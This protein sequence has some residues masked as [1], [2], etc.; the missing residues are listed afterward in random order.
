VDFLFGLA[1][2]SRW[3]IRSKAELAEAAEHSQQSGKSARRF[4]DFRPGRHATAGAASVASSPRRNGRRQANPRFVVTSLSREEHEARHLYEKALLRTRRDWRTGSRS[5]SSTL[6]RST[7]PKQWR[8]TSCGCGL[9][10]WP[11]C[12]CAPLR[13]IGLAHTQFVRASCGHH[14]PQAAQDR[15]PLVRPACVASSSPCPRLFGHYQAEYR[16]PMPH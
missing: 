11:M 7:R 3:S 4:R 16:P 9:L 8:A 1:R 14:P 2:N 10:R 5:A 15:R 12:C 6:C 13:R